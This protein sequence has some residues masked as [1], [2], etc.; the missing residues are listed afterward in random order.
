[1]V[2]IMNK[3]NSMMY[4]RH[5]FVEHPDNNN[6]SQKKLKYLISITDN[7][8]EIRAERNLI[9]NIQPLSQVTIG[10]YNKMQKQKNV[11]ISVV[12]AE[13]IFKA[14]VDLCNKGKKASFSYMQIIPTDQE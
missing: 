14:M 2:R 13:E 7:P 8:G 1:M 9:I 12:T 5:T 10:E 4:F 6:L 11:Q 3:K